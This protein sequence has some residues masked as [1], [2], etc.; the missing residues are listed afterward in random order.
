MS[1]GAS[2]T[3]GRW[4]VLPIGEKTANV[5]ARTTGDGLANL[6]VRYRDLDAE[7]V[8]EEIV[9]SQTLLGFKPDM[10]SSKFRNCL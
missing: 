9:F 8:E 4:K 2:D 6:D 10:W 5:V 7:G 3:R 1:F